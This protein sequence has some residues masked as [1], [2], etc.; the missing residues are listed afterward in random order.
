VESTGPTRRKQAVF[1]GPRTS[2][3]FIG[4]SNARASAD[5]RKIKARRPPTGSLAPSGAARRETA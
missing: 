3:F 4:F 5:Q 2:P 1:L